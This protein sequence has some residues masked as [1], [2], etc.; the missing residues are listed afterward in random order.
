M[1]NAPC[2]KTERYQIWGPNSFSSLWSGNLKSSIDQIL[3]LGAVSRFAKL[4]PLSKGYSTVIL[5]NRR[6][7][8][9][10]ERMCFHH[11]IYQ[12][13]MVW[14][15]SFS[16][17]FQTSV[18]LWMHLLQ[19]VELHLLFQSVISSLRL[20]PALYSQPFIQVFACRSFSSYWINN[21]S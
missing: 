4:P 11:E 10:V 3:R 12:H 18:A 21:S 20:Y 13:E 15:L 9:E 7:A 17:F 19:G 6:V 2:E 8:Y 5:P 16:S 14:V 1:H